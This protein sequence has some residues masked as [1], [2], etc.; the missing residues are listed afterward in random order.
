MSV[1]I[2]ERTDEYVVLAVKIPFSETMLETEEG[3][4]TVLN[5]AGTMASGEALQQYDTEGEPLEIEGRQWTSKCKISRTSA[6]EYHE[7]RHLNTG[8]FGG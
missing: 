6:P 2:L 1:S 7:L 5:A 8:N 4:Q 3:I